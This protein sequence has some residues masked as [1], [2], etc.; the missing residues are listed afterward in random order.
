[1]HDLKLT[2]RKI[3]ISANFLLLSALQCEASGRTWLRVQTHAVLSIASLASGLSGRIGITSGRDPYK[4]LS[5]SLLSLPFAHHC[6]FI[7]LSCYVECFSRRFLPRFWH[8]QHISSH[9]MIFSMSSFV[10]LSLC[11]F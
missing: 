8:S 7:D 9:S 3:I 5:I 4:F 1:M 11:A 6:I 2:L 10:L